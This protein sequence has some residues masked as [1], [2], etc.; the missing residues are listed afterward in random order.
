MSRREIKVKL[1]RENR[2]NHNEN[3][4]E[5]YGFVD[6]VIQTITDEVFEE[7]IESVRLKWSN[8]VDNKEDLPQEAEVG[9]TILVRSEGKVYR[10]NG[11]EW[12]EIQDIDISLIDDVENRL[13]ERLDE[14][15]GYVDS[16]DSKRPITVISA[17]EPSEADIWYEIL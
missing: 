3:Y 8:P 4:E 15:K 1:D 17:D 11:N 13:D 5:L 6:N 2:N 9:E 7:I 14:L 12:V 10:F 16:E